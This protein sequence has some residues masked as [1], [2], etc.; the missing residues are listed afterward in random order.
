MKVCECFALFDAVPPKGMER[1][2]GQFRFAKAKVAEP[3]PPQWDIF[4]SSPPFG[5]FSLSTTQCNFW[6]RND[7]FQPCGLFF[8]SIYF[9]RKRCDTTICI[10][11]LKW[12]HPFCYGKVKNIYLKQ[13]YFYWEIRKK[14]LLVLFWMGALNCKYDQLY[15]KK[16]SERSTHTFC[17]FRGTNGVIGFSKGITKGSGWIDIGQILPPQFWNI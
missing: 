15:R 5:V 6:T 2:T 14:I 7:I 13:A 10:F 12:K 11:L 16:K 17:I 3:P 9:L 8:F 1:Q 4:G